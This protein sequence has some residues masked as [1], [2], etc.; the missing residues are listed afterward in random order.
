MASIDRSSILCTGN[1]RD[2]QSGTGTTQ[3]NVTPYKI[4]VSA[5]IKVFIDDKQD[6]STHTTQREV[7]M[8]C[9]TCLK[10]IQS[11]DTTYRQ[12]LQQLA[13]PYITNRVRKK[14][15]DKISVITSDPNE[16]LDLIGSLKTLILSQTNVIQKSSIVGLFIRR[17]W[18]YYDKLSFSATS[19]LF[20]SLCDYINDKNDSKISN[21]VN[22]SINVENK[23]ETCPQIQ[24]F[25]S[26]QLNLIQINEKK[27][28]SPFDLLEQIKNNCQTAD[29]NTSSANNDL[30]DVHFLKY[31]NALRVDEFAAAKESLM[32]YFDG[33]ANQMNRCWSALNLAILH[34]H[35]GHH[36]WTIQT[37]K[38]CISAA[39]E[40]N[41]EKC[42]EFALMW[43]SRVLI[44]TDSD[45]DISLLLNHLQTKA[46]ELGLPYISSISQLQSERIKIS[47]KSLLNTSDNFVKPTISSTSS[48]GVLAVRHSM[49]DVLMMSYSS[50]SALLNLYG[51]ANLA[52][53]TS[54]VLLHLNVVEPVGESN[55]Y[56]VNESTCIGVRN[57]ALHM[58]RNVGQ[59]VIA[60]DM[61][62]R[63][64]SLFSQYKSRLNAICF[65]ALA[66]IEFE[67]D[68]NQCNWR[69]ALKCVQLINSCDR[70]EANIR[71]AHLK[72]KQGDKQKAI[73]LIDETINCEDIQK[74][75]VNPFLKINAMLLKGKLLND[76]TIILDCIDQC[77]QN[78][79]L[80]L[81]VSSLVELAA[82]LQ[83]KQLIS[84]SQHIIDSVMIR[85][86]ANGTIGDIAKAYY[87]SA[88]NHFRNYEEM[89]GQ[90]NANLID[91]DK[92]LKSNERAI[93]LWKLIDDKH[94]LKDSF[95][96]N[97][98][99]YHKKHDFSQRNYYALQVRLI[100]TNQMND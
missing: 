91:L 31:L 12:F 66:E 77:S 23:S 89:S 42:L 15:T 65:Q 40:S 49:N 24:Y 30:N 50:R 100:V 5:L 7:G 56:H 78:N 8:F 70:L 63:L 86:L 53:L 17:M 19:Q 37:I 87:I 60:R 46:N 62:M 85:L 82:I 13:Q 2:G 68:L 10:L 1:Q 54:Q 27:A 58:W 21:T 72:A 29:V 51:A 48:P 55:V 22:T 95:T 36:E 81:E 71:L 3:F 16:L 94:S 25:I 92:A 47:S 38:E 67:L 4:C 64:S 93:Q 76:M 90:T 11:L 84:Q 61:L 57:I 41:D 9:L 52:A 34:S 44:K 39:Q 73:N 96:L 75:D 99:I 6:R 43:V 26:K 32:A 88:G 98:K 79:L 97:T 28:L 59:Y 45:C 35:F 14:L 83:Q 69:S 20:H 33:N 74:K 80:G 18:L